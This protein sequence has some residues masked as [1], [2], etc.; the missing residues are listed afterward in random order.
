[1]IPNPPFSTSYLKIFMGS[2]F[3]QP[4]ARLVDLL[5][6][7][8]WKI[9]R[10]ETVRFSVWVGIGCFDHCSSWFWYLF[11]WCLDFFSS[12]RFFFFA[13]G[14]Y[15]HLLGYLSSFV[16][17][18]WKNIAWFHPGWINVFSAEKRAPMAELI[19][20]LLEF[21]FCMVL[22]NM[23][24]M[25]DLNS[26]HHC[27][28]SLFWRIV[29]RY[30]RIIAR[31]HG[32]IVGILSQAGNLSGMI[33]FCSKS[34][35]LLERWV[36]IYTPE[37]KHSCRPVEKLMGDDDPKHIISSHCKPQKLWM[38]HNLPKLFAE[39]RRGL[40][41]YQKIGPIGLFIFSSNTPL[42]IE[43]CR[44]PKPR[45][46]ANSMAQKKRGWCIKVKK[47]DQQKD[48]CGCMVLP[49]C[50][51]WGIMLFCLSMVSDDGWYGQQF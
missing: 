19:Q 47:P 26:A 36:G 3:G 2:F 29:P 48:C 18:D 16:S 23:G 49:C 44:W 46:G 5:P 17:S 40:V 42:E 37:N 4:R 35:P 41:F 32:Q 22:F 25:K 15:S 33:R 34:D 51:P 13:D 27:S 6:W 11:K 7:N 38:V 24:N 8:G 9:P 31:N 14:F 45:M 20:R 28:C 50:A 39:L 21:R 1:M 10:Y 43:L 12:G 30:E